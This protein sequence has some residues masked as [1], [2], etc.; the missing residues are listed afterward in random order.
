MTDNYLTF[1][2]LSIILDLS[3]DGECVGVLLH[4]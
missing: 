1:Y 2:I 4:I 3:K